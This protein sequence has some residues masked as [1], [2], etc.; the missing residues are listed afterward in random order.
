MHI[1][2]NNILT[3]DY[4][5]STMLPLQES[6]RHALNV[7]YEGEHVPGSPYTLKVAGAPDP[8]KVLM[9]LLVVDKAKLLNNRIPW[10]YTYNEASLCDKILTCTW[11]LWT[12]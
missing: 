10:F 7:K 5:K 2:E 6:G 1:N 9:S 4:L 11:L 3:E 12:L 8:S